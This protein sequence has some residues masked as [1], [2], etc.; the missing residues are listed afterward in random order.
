MVMVPATVQNSGRYLLNRWTFSNQTWYRDASSWTAVTQCLI[1]FVLMMSSKRFNLLLFPVF[2]VKITVW[3]NTIKI[4][5]FPL[6][7]QHSACY[8]WYILAKSNVRKSGWKNNMS[9]CS[10][11]ILDHSDIERNRLS[12]VIC[13]THNPLHPPTWDGGLRT[14]CW[15][16]FLSRFLQFLMHVLTSSSA[17]AQSKV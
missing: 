17:F 8:C 7:L 9:S 4:L 5:S 1:K 15:Y 14:V 16:Q 11:T 2:K 6:C 3:A 10:H 12:M 13:S